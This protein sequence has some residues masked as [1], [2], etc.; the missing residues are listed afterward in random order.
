MK[1]ILMQDVKNLGKK[2]TLV[3][4]SDGYARNYLIPKGLA[5]EATPSAIN[6]MKMRE[7]AEKA[8]KENELANARKL[9]E[10]LNGAVIT[11]AAKAGD[12]GKLFGSITAMDISEKLEKD[13][14][15]QIDK[16]KIV[17]ADAIKSL[18]VYDIEVKLHT[19]V[20][21]VIKVQVMNKE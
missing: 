12:N 9:A 11:F 7:K 5:K 2:N 14:N 18:G 19:G 15:V 6:E 4:V 10:K 16:R 20:S 3:E 1:V 21:A 8:K 13:L 17:L